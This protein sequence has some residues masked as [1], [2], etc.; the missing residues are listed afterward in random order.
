[1]KHQAMTETK[2]PS[3]VHADG[4]GAFRLCAAAR[5]GGCSRSA[6]DFLFLLIPICPFP[7]WTV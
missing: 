7:A 2:Q 1:M 6:L 4:S 5:R 3:F